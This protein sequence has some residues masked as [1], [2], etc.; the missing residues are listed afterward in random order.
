MSPET[1]DFNLFVLLDRIRSVYNVGSIFRSCDSASVDKLLLCGYTAVPPHPKLEKTALGSL[2]SV[3]WEHHCSTTQA[4]KHLKSQGT[5]I[6]AMEPL[7]TAT[8]IYDLTPHHDTCLIFGHEETGIDPEALSLADE[9][10][11][12]PHFGVKESLNVAVAAG[13]AIYE[14]QRKRLTI[15]HEKMM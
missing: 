5:F 12:I 2:T 7:D 1:F 15:Q 4:I 9:V 10:V 6:V 11:K 14:F 3:A 13:I 8:S